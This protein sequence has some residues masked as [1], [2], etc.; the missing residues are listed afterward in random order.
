MLLRGQEIS[1][2][3]RQGIVSL[4]H[5]DKC[6]GPLKARGSLPLLLMP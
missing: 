1:H 2:Q 6:S 5:A 4:I 3:R